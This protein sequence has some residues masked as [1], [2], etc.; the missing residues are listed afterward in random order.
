MA[1][2]PLIGFIG[3]GFIGKNYADDFV[4]RG[5]EVVRYSLDPAHQAN[6]D[7]IKDTVINA[8]PLL[9]FDVNK[10]IRLD[11]SDDGNLFM[12]LFG[13]V[14]SAANKCLSSFVM[15]E[16]AEIQKVNETACWQN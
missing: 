4:S 10:D 11:P 8:S 16:N 12:N 15:L 1:A 14:D 3:Q 5:Y 6:K 2:K 7:K 13:V 9:R